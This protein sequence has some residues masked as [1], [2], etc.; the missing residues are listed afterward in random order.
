ML[1]PI[2]QTIQIASDLVWGP[3]TIALLLGTGLW[4]TIR[5]RFVQIRLLGEAL[6]RFRPPSAEGAKGALSPFQAFMTGLA[7]SVGTGNIAGVA[8]AVVAGGPGAIFWIWCYGFFATAIKLTEATLAVRFRQTD[9]KGLSAGPMFYLRDGLG[10][11]KLAAAYALIAGLAALTTTPFTQPNSI[12]VVFESE[13]AIPTWATG[14]VLAVLAW[15]VVI[16]GVRSIGRAAAKLAPTMVVVYLAGGLIVLASNLDTVPGVFALILR[17][18]FS[19]EAVAG[20]ALGTGMMLAVRYG[21]AR[22]IY[23]NEAGYGTAAVAYGSARS[24]EPIQQGLNA[25]L[26]VYIVSFV[27]A[28]ISGLTILVSGVW[29]SGLNSTALVAAAFDSAMPF[30]GFVVAIC[31]L[32]FGYTTLIGWGYYGEQ[33]LQ[34]LFGKRIIVPYRWIYCGLVVFGA[35]TRVEMVWTWGD[36]MNGLQIFPNIVAL[37]GLSGLVATMLRERETGE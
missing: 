10:S 18:A 31:A 34:Y 7:G 16:G 35:V 32:L 30:G 21:L 14:A 19:T 28:S 22:G 24:V 23:A 20:G 12:A 27:T 4:L 1:G 9:S 13:M 33:Y 26:E 37:I 6:R 5:Y 15:L 17:E 11:P 3:W 25:M 2:H 36:L 29:T 8:T